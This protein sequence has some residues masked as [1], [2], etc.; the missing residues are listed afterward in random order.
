M[1]RT[2]AGFLSD[3]LKFSS[4][5]ALWSLTERQ[6]VAIMGSTAGRTEVARTPVPTSLY[7]ML[8]ID[9]SIS[10]TLLL[11]LLNIKT[12]FI[13][14]SPFELLN[15]ICYTSLRTSVLVFVTLFS[16]VVFTSSVFNIYP[17]ILY[18]SIHSVIIYQ[19]PIAC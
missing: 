4:G 9:D 3:F 11:G 10:Y 17:S 2:A 7:H 18:P 15:T 16:L 5:V 1:R 14:K 12:N 6:G 19:V 8:P 13:A